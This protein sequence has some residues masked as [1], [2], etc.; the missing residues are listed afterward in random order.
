MRSQFGWPLT[1]EMVGSEPSAQSVTSNTATSAGVI[2]WRASDLIH[3]LSLHLQSGRR[4]SSSPAGSNGRIQ[5]R[6]AAHPALVTHRQPA[7]N[8]IDHTSVREATRVRVCVART[9][10]GCAG[11]A[12]GS[13]RLRSHEAENTAR[14]EM[15][16]Q[17]GQQ[18]QFSVLGNLSEVNVYK[19]TILHEALS[20]RP[21]SA[22]VTFD[23]NSAVAQ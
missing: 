14:S 21:S 22:H 20:Y 13:E 17:K 6:L 5:P 23:S 12:R 19:S 3:A 9:C 4:R 16:P 2:Q 1:P 18:N 8:L 11:C 10:R 7:Y 15:S